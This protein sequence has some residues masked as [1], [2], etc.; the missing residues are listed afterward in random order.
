MSIP[1][2]GTKT[3]LHIDYDSFFASV[4]QQANPFLRNKPIMIT[5]YDIKKGIAS[6]ASIQAKKL[7]VKTGMPYFEAIKVCPTIIAVPGNF[8]KYNYIHKETI[9]IFQNY[10]DLI[11][12]FSIDE[13]FLDVTHT[14]KFF[15]T[16]EAIASQI[17][18]DIRDNFGEIVTCSVG[19]APNKLLAKVAS[20]INKPNGFYKVTPENLFQTIDTLKITDFCGLG[21]RTQERLALLGITS[22]SDIRATPY[23]A[24]ET[25]FGPFR[26]HFLKNL[27]FGLGDNTVKKLE[28]KPQVKSVSHQHTLTKPTKDLA[29]LDSNLQ[30]L[31][32][33]AGTRLR[34]K[35]LKGKTIVVSLREHKG[36]FLTERITLK[37]HIN[38]GKELSDTVKNLLLKFRPEKPIRLVGVH[39]SNLENADLRQLELFG[40]EKLYKLVNL[41]DSINDRFG[42]FTIFP[43]RVLVADKQKTGAFQR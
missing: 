5:G 43:A 42:S 27:S 34:K 12:I 40:N 13:A 32:E 29:V 18:Q 23:F 22:L 15:K 14:L 31:A 19:A 4:E 33:M 16:P 10:T 38:S 2:L 36:K 17:K 24:L 41:Q 37:K 28:D 7:G 35:N 20:E 21:S 3:I 25:E 1:N 9:K 30:K 39:V 8:A 11:E 6:A 26:A